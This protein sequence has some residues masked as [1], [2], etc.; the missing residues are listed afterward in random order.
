MTELIGSSTY[1][2][3]ACPS[4]GYRYGHVEQDHKPVITVYYSDRAD[5]AIVGFR[6]PQC[7]YEY[8]PK[9]CCPE[10]IVRRKDN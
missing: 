6:C 7:N 5:L 9:R 10:T 3:D 4:C 1:S 2:G 8:M